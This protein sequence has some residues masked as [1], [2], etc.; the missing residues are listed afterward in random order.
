MVVEKT[1]VINGGNSDISKKLI[2]LESSQKKIIQ[3]IRENNETTQQEGIYQADAT[4][5]EKMKE[6]INNIFDSYQ[7]I[8]EYVH[9]IGSIFLKPLHNMELSDWNQVMEL[10]INSIFYALKNILP[11]M[12]KQKSGNIVLISSVAAQVGLMNHDA[13][14]AS[15]GA[16]EA[17]TRSLSMTY[18][19]YGIR[20]NCIAPSLINTKM[21][22]FLVQNELA[23]KSTI[24]LNA[25]K[26]IGEAMDVAN[27]IS[28]L[29]SEKSS[30]ITG[31]IISVDGGLSHIR[32][33]P[34]I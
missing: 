3:I 29:L 21:A 16:V 26:R 25:I 31:Q 34:K 28:F 24:S 15:K 14:S 7:R 5:I 1:L 17:L 30:F 10:N 8:D 22:K 12:Q 11:L 13:I 27:V 2:S 20:V 6:T 9:L 23:V 32:T 18:G 4:N 19:N 33:P